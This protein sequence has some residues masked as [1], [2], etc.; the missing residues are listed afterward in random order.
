M[1][2]PR[3]PRLLVAVLLLLAATLLIHTALLA[4]HR[5]REGRDGGREPPE[6]AKDGIPSTRNSP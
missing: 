2:P 1:A 5:W 4:T 3:A 6:A